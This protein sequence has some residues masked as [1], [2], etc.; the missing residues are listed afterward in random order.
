MRRERERR[1]KEK[2][3]GEDEIVILPQAIYLSQVKF[4]CK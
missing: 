1:E 4:H 2:R 3:E